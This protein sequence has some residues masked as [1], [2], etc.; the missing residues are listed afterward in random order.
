MS[1]H[2]AFK[3]RHAFPFFGHLQTKPIFQRVFLTSYGE[4]SFN[5]L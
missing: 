4:K 3:K 5:N 2:A 1:S